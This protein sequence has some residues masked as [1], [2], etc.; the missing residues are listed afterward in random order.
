MCHPPFKVFTERSLAATIG[1]FG[2]VPPTK[3]WPMLTVVWKLLKN[4]LVGPTADIIGF[5]RTVFHPKAQLVADAKVF[6]VTTMKVSCSSWPSGLPGS[7]SSEQSDGSTLTFAQAG[8][9]TPT[10]AQP[11]PEPHA[12]IN[13]CL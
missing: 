10:M 1:C 11:V 6:Y 4:K 2:H 3:D 7:I 8:L 9:L 12:S 5:Y 13:H